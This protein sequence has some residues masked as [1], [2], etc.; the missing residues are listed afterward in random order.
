MA[1]F[2]AFTII[3]TYIPVIAITASITFTFSNCTAVS[4]LTTIDA[5]TSSQAWQPVELSMV[6]ASQQWS[7]Y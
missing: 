4:A 5:I 6:V 7:V 3:T 2:H 1:F